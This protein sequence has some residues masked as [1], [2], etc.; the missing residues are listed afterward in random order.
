MMADEPTQNK[1]LIKKKKT[2]KKIKRTF[3]FETSGNNFRK[4]LPETTSGKE[5]SF[6]AEACVRLI[7][8][9]SIK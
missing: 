8:I 3:R 1:L 5:Q 4:Q 7:M 9:A 6:H 2:E